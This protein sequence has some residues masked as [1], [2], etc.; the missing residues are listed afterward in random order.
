M[1]AKVTNTPYRNI[2]LSAKKFDHALTTKI[3][4]T[5]PASNFEEQCE[6]LEHNPS[7]GNNK[8]AL[9]HRGLNS[10]KNNLDVQKV[11]EAILGSIDAAS[12][13]Y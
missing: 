12:S 8:N 5:E 13:E 3:G 11:R 1:P 10:V 4:L 6:T 7:L 2:K 9:K